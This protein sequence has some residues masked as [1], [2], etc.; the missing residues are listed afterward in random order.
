MRS[1]A[2]ELYEYALTL[3]TENDGF[4]TN[5]GKIFNKA[6]EIIRELEQPWISVD[7]MMPETGK[8]VVTWDG[9]DYCADVKQRDGSF[10]YDG[11]THWM[12]IQEVPE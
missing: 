5:G 2:D 10:C 8:H 9:A 12:E 1:R 11:V 3:P 6:S 7:D 4:F